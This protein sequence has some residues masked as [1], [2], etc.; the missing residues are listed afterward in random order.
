MYAY[1]LMISYGKGKHIFLFPQ[2]YQ[3]YI[4][5]IPFVTD[6]KVQLL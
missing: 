4:F 5:G 2:K 6:N 3:Q 1:H